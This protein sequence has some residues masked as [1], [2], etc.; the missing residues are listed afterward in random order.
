L[1]KDKDLNRRKF[2]EKIGLLEELV[3]MMINLESLFDVICDCYFKDPENEANLK[4][5]EKIAL[6]TLKI[7]W[8]TCC[9]REKNKKEKS[10]EEQN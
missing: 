8:K 3:S 10:N 5:K 4:I 9:K 1:E 2:F 6:S 7:Q